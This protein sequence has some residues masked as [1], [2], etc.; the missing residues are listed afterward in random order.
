MLA[1][2]GTIDGVAS[3]EMDNRG[4][5]LRLRLDRDE[6]LSEVRRTIEELGY[7]VE[8]KPHCGPIEGSE[9]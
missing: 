4:E 8:G 2:L 9:R 7:R 5:R 1:R 6:V 3:A